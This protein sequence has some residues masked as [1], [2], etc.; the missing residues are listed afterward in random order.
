M[1]SSFHGWQEKMEISFQ[2]EKAEMVCH[3]DCSPAQEAKQKLEELLQKLEKEKEKREKIATK[4]EEASSLRNEL[5]KELHQKAHV[6]DESKLMENQLED[7]SQKLAETE[8]ALEAAEDRMKHFEQQVRAWNH[9]LSYHFVLILDNLVNAK[10]ILG[11]CSLIIFLRNYV[12]NLGIYIHFI[13]FWYIRV[14]SCDNS[15]ADYLSIIIFLK[16]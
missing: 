1:I 5:E 7:L 15:Y 3:G 2:K 8:R 16:I 13:W 14:I 6:E 9:E 11:T 10:S 4:L 12:V